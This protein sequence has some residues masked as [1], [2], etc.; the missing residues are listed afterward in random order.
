MRTLG[1][2]LGVQR[3]VF[4]GELVGEQKADAY[5]RASVFVLPTRNENFGVAVAEA[6]SHGTPAIVTKGAPWGGLHEHRCGWWVDFGVEPLVSALREAMNTSPSMSWEMGQR[7][8]DWM[9]RE[10]SWCAI[11]AQMEEVYKWVLCGR[12]PADAPPSV[13]FD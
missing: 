12:H 7:G 3:V 9:R 2:E 11:G 5:Q 4:A 10:F 8:R 13:T 6:L 1:A